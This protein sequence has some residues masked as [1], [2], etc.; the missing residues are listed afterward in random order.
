[1]PLA[2]RARRAVAGIGATLEPVADM[3]PASNDE[4]PRR[5]L[6]RHLG[7]VTLATASAVCIGVAAAELAGIWWAVLFAGAALGWFAFV[8]QTFE[9]DHEKAS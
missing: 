9:E 4:R 5:H 7:S 3:P 8:R 2:A 1:M 6:P